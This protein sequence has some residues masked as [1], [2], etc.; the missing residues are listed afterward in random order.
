MRKRIKLPASP[1]PGRHWT[2]DPGIVSSNLTAGTNFSLLVVQF[3]TRDFL[4]RLI[5]RRGLEKYSRI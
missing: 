5:I 3:H 2:E 4:F 1:S